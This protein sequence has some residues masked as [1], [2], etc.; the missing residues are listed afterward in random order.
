[1][2]YSTFIGRFQP[3]HSGHIKVIREALK[4]TDKII[5]IVGSSNQPRS[6]RNPFTFDERYELFCTWFEHNELERIIFVPM[7][8]CNYRDNV[9]IRNI[10]EA[11][12]TIAKDATEIYLA[13]HRKDGT[14]YYLDLFPTWKSISVEN[15]MN[16]NSTEIRENIFNHPDTILGG[17]IKDIIKKPNFQELIKEYQIVKKYKEAWA[18]EPFPPTFNTVDAIVVQSGHVLMVERGASPGIGLLA[19]PGGFINQNETLLDAAIRELKEETKI[20]VPSKVLRGSIVASHTFDDPYR[21]A[22]GRTITHAFYIELDKSKNLPKVKG[23]D[24]AANALWIPIEKLDR[25]K[26]FEDHLDIINYFLK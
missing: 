22:R 8:D 5:V 17:P 11:V 12:S 24:D 1:M 2:R 21:S 7:E 13:G 15:H 10:K 20:D 6:I 19:L 16:Y 9:W 18:A 3:P 25:S 23:S 4:V 14:S 26:I